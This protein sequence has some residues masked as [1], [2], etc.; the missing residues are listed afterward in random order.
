M[1]IRRLGVERIEEKINKGSYVDKL[2][3]INEIG[4]KTV[5]GFLYMLE[6]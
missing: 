3:E 4:L 1:E 5:C 2:L 6:G